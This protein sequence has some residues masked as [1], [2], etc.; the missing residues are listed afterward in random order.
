MLKDVRR[1]RSR[2]FRDAIERVR[3]VPGVRAAGAINGLPLLLTRVMRSPLF[4]FSATDPAVFA[5]I[6]VPLSATAM[7]AGYLPARRATRVEPSSRCA[8][9]KRRSAFG[10][11]GT[12]NREPRTANGERRT[13]NRERRLSPRR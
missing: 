7:L 13:A 1:A 3:T 10:V 2:F 5:A 8:I 6:V 12:E 4:G 11:R 9:A